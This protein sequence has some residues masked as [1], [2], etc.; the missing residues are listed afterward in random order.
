MEC[1]T[2]KKEYKRDTS[3]HDIL[4]SNFN[5]HFNTVKL[6][7][8]LRRTFEGNRSSRGFKIHCQNVT[9]KLQLSAEISVKKRTLCTQRALQSWF[10]VVHTT[11]TLKMIYVCR[12]SWLQ[13]NDASPERSRYPHW[14]LPVG[15]LPGRRRTLVP[16]PGLGPQQLCWGT[17]RWGAE[18][19][20]WGSDYS[21]STDKPWPPPHPNTDRLI[22]LRSACNTN[23]HITGYCHCP[24]TH[25]HG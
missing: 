13:L 18:G 14:T 24:S 4:W 23:T 20:E 17:G 7:S 9:L 10:V 11:K 8:Y 3:R 22:C 6:L 1:A 12:N 15:F 21:S 19:W 5:W 16:A 25:G 2:Y